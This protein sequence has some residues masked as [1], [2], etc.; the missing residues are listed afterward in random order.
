MAVVGI[1]DAQPVPQA[2]TG[3]VV[4]RIYALV[5]AMTTGIKPLSQASKAVR[6]HEAAVPRQFY[7]VDDDEK[8]PLPVHAAQ[9][10]KEGFSR[11]RDVGWLPRRYRRKA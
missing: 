3:Y 1:V 2:R 5:G 8:D 11:S 4:T 7:S 9:Y 6:T 10:I